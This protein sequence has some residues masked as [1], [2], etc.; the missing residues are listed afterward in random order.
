[1]GG[2]NLFR[3]RL[4]AYIKLNSISGTE[5]SVCLMCVH[6]K[7]RF[8][9]KFGFRRCPHEYEGSGMELEMVIE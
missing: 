2:S 7:E 6:G 3:G 8:Y 9:E 1:M 5:V 4:L